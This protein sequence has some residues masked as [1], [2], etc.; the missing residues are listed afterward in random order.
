[1]LWL[2]AV[3]LS[4]GL[5]AG[6]GDQW[7]ERTT[8]KFT[9]PVMVPGTTLQAGTYVFQLMNSPTNRHHVQILND[10]GETITTT[11]AIPT[12]RAE[13]KG[14]VVLKLNP[15]DKGVPPAIAAYFYP[16]SIY[17]HQFVYPED[18]AKQIAQRTKTVVLSKDIPGTDLEAGTLQVYDAAGMAKPFKEDPDAVASWQKWQRGRTS[19]ANVR[20]PASKSPAS[21]APAVDADF[22]GQRVKLRDLEEAPTTYIGKTV[23][24]DG[25]VEEVLGPRLF[26]IDEPNWADLDGELLVYVPTPLAALVRD[27]DRVTV[28]GTVKPFVEAEFEKEWGWL[29]LDKSVEVDLAKRPVL[30]ASRIVGGNNNIAMVID[31]KTT[32][33]P[34]GTSGSADAL[35]DL[36]SVAG[37]DED[38]IGKRVTL[39][40]VRV[41]RTASDGGFFAD[42][43]EHTVFVLPAPNQSVRQGDTVTVEGVVLELP[44]HMEDKLNGPSD[45]NDDIY[46]Y[47]TA[48]K[49]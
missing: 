49:R 12:K 37:G 41:E 16:G 23:S 19:T 48:V 33:R 11:M 14:D 26:T 21:S 27:N 22:K 7:N 17:G 28:S 47:A 43:G 6:G 24:I 9:E 45:L 34:V 30:V 31:A 35:T 5:A 46:V 42:A 38:L 18:Q 40:G 10:K 8:L 4:A 29:G 13:A 20:S 25:E 39:S 1:M 2:S 44:R 15:T 3:V 32:N 36:R